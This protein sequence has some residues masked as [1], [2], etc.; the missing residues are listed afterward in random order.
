MTSLPPSPTVVLRA[1]AKPGSTLDVATDLRA[2]TRL[3]ATTL[4]VEPPGTSGADDVP[5]LE[6]P[7][8]DG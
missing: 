7:A 8:A 6:L 1:N 5:T 2:L 3:A 4:G